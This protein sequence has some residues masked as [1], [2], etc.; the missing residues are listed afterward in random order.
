MGEKVIT[1]IKPGT[2]F[3]VTDYMK[4]IEYPTGTTGVFSH[5]V[6]RG[7]AV[8]TLAVVMFKIGKKGSHTIRRV[9]IDTPLFKSENKEA[10]DYYSTNSD[11]I[12]HIEPQTKCKNVISDFTDIEFIAWAN[13][14]VWYLYNLSK[15]LISASVWNGMSKPYIHR[16]SGINMRFKRDDP[17]AS[18]Y[19]TSEKEDFVICMRKEEMVLVK[20]AYK[21]RQVLLA[22]LLESLYNS[23]AHVEYKQQEADMIKRAIDSTTEE[24]HIVNNALVSY[25]LGY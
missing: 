6:P 21:Y 7:R 25:N 23:K 9:T 22:Y 5:I 10:I 20:H 24:S 19:N 17:S 15:M 12:I 2:V 13:A 1:T 18:F 14:Y 3:T 8:W 16:A 11:N 4:N